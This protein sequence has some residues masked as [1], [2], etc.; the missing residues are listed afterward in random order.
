VNRLPDY[1]RH[2]IEAIRRIEDYTA[3][4]DRDGFL[5]SAI[6]QDAV[7]RNI[8]IIGEAGRSITKNHPDFATRNPHLRLDAAYKMRNAVS[9]GYFAVDLSIVWSTISDDLKKLSRDVQILIDST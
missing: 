9:H 2:I 4:M 7:I 5:A 6:T 3:G 8:E 1:L